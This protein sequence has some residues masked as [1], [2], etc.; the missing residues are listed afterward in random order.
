MTQRKNLCLIF[1]CH[2]GIIAVVDDTY[3][4]WIELDVTL[5]EC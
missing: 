2:L 5:G 1:D 3:S 4:G